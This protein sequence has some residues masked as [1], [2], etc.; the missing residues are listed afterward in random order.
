[1]NVLHYRTFSR[2][3]IAR[4]S[5]FQAKEHWKKYAPF[6]SERPVK[7]M[8]VR[9]FL[10]PEDAIISFTIFSRHVYEPKE[11]AL[12]LKLLSSSRNFVDV[13]AN[14]G[15][16]TCLAAKR[17]QKVYSFEPEPRAL[18]LLK[19]NVALN[20][21]SNVT[22]FPEAVS[23]TEDTVELHLSTTENKG[24]HSIVWDSHGKSVLVPVTTLDAR[25][26]PGHSLDVLKID[27]Q[28]AE[29]NVLL[30]ARNLIQQ[31]QIRHIIME[32]NPEVW[33][34]KNWILEEMSNY[35]LDPITSVSYHMSLRSNS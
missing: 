24:D 10:N 19:R 27:V 4:I 5:A 18:D 31:G 22:I 23:D 3:K 1:M 15:Y 35:R 25:F 33:A 12:I 6:A 16:Y 32:W 14:L 34:A 29:P 2:K 13:G 21:F 26:F 17:V 30:G 28:G 7:I 11:T 20:K 9:Y 8:G